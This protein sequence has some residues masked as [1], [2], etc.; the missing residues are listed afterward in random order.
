MAETWLVSQNATID[1][2]AVLAWEVP[3]RDP[4][5]WSPLPSTL[6]SHPNPSGSFCMLTFPDGECPD[7]Q[8]SAEALELQIWA[9]MGKLMSVTQ[10]VRA[11][12]SSVHLSSWMIPRQPAPHPQPNTPL[13][14][15]PRHSRQSTFS[16]R[17][18][19]RGPGFLCDSPSYNCE[20]EHAPSFPP[21]FIF[22][23]YLW[24]PVNH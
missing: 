22:L 14:P 11:L 19:P 12:V 8:N 5:S 15:S 1:V 18:S 23:C 3:Q 17:H 16:T 20:C 13:T 2:P 7:Q 6:L 24:C 10:F 4:A 9:S 21:L